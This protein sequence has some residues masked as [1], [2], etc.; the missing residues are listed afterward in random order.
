MDYG[1]L[2]GIGLG[3][4]QLLNVTLDAMVADERVPPDVSQLIGRP[5]TPLAASVSAMEVVP[6]PVTSPEMVMFWLAVM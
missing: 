1:E 5:T 3:V 6:E 4:G 2:R